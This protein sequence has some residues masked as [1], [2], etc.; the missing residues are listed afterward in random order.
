MGSV[1][2]YY[3]IQNSLFFAMNAKANSKA[4]RLS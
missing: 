2:T 4:N 3:I 1:Q